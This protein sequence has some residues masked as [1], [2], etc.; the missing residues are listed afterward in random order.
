MKLISKALRMAR[1]KGITVLPAIHKFVHV[2]SRMKWA[3]L[4]LLTATEHPR[5]LAGTR[6]S[7]HRG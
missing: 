7:S 4:P 2:C 6:L 5:I 3:I 1:G